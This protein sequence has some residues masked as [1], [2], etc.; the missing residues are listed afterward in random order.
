MNTKYIIAA[1]AII[2]LVI[3]AAFIYVYYQGQ[4][5]AQLEALHNLVDDT[6]YTTSM[7]AIPN[8]IISLAPS[9]TEIVFA[10]GLDEKVVGVDS[11]S[12][13]PYD[14]SAWIAAG[15]MTS[16]GDF[17]NPNMEVVASLEP[18]LILA[19]GGVQAETVGT[20]RDLG[21]KV[22]VLDPPNINGVLMNIELIGN[23]TGKT[24]EAKALIND[25]TS[26]IDAVVNEVA[27][28]ASK[29]K[30]YYET[31]YDPTSLWTAG[32]KAWQNELIEKAGG[33][34]IFAD[35]QLDYFQSSAEAVIQRN[36]DVILLPQEGMGKGEPFWVSLDAVKARPGWN[37]ISAVQNDRVVTVDSN[38]IARAGPRVADILEDLAE[39]FHPELF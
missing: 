6:G 32:A 4:T 13:Y 19:T 9:T 20:L 1:V 8:K 30:V 39:T 12:D 23:A 35:Q 3:S 17:S 5:D 27:N 22:L 34:N 37:S 36:P 15:N 25:I 26:R 24:A 18:D 16:I 11:Y 38:T 10:L 29:P 33:V 21:Y 31:W 28:A 14:F 2:A 7:D